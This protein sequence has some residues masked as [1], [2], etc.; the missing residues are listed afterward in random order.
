MWQPDLLTWRDDIL[1]SRDTFAGEI[2]RLEGNVSRYRILRLHA[3]QFAS[4]E[5]LDYDEGGYEASERAWR[6]ALDPYDSDSNPD[7]DFDIDSALIGRRRFRIGEMVAGYDRLIG[8]MANTLLSMS[9]PPA[10]E[11]WVAR[12]PAEIRK[13][14]EVDDCELRV[15]FA[16][17]VDGVR[18][19]LRVAHGAADRARVEHAVAACLPREEFAAREVRAPTVAGLPATPEEPSAPPRT[20]RAAL[21]ALCACFGR[22]EPAP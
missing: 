3:P 4:E 21:R 1:R 13:I 5:R 19:C 8:H 16:A 22:R 17:V 7:P 11:A 12:A 2:M 20:I 6:E 9:P 14:L 15:A 18:D 10:V